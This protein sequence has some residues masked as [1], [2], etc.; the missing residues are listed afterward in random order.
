MRLIRSLHRFV[1]ALAV[2]TLG[3]VGR[4]L[5]SDQRGRAKEFCHE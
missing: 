2:F 5:K 3:C 4:P 1:C